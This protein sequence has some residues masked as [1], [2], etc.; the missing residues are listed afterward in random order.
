MGTDKVL[1]PFNAICTKSQDGAVTVDV[2]DR[3]YVRV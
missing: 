2:K 1:R 3:T